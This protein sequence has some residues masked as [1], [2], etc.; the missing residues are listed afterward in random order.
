MTRPRWH[1]LAVQAGD[2]EHAGNGGRGAHLGVAAYPVSGSGYDN[3]VL[4]FGVKEG[5]IPAL[6][7]LRRG[8]AERDVDDLGAVVHRPAHRLRNLVLVAF[9]GRVGRTEPG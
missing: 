8:A 1:V 9:A 3:H 2:G 6:R 4:L 5:G 7:P